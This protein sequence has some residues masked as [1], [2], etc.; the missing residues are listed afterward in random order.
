M[1]RSRQF[2]VRQ[3]AIAASVMLISGAQPACAQSSDFDAWLEEVRSEAAQRGLTA[4]AVIDTLA[5]IQL[6][7]RV[8]ELDQRQPELV[9]TFW[10][11]VDARVTPGR[12]AI[13]EGL[14]STYETLLDEVY[15]RYGVQPRIIVALWGMESDY[16]RAQGDFDV[17]SSL[18]T[19]AFD[20]RR[21]ALFRSQLFALLALINQGDVP[22]DVR[23]SW[24]G[25][26]GQPQFM[27]TTFSRYAVDFDGDGRRDLQGDVADVFASA[28]NYLALSG[29]ERS[30]GWGQEVLLPSAFDFAETGLDERKPLEEWQRLGVRQIDGRDLPLRAL[31]G[32]ILLPAGAKGPAFLVYDNFRA[33]LAWNNSALF[34]LAVGILSDELAG[35]GPLQTPRPAEEETLS[36]YDV[37][38]LQ[39]RLVGLGFAA[40]EADGVVGEQTRRAIRLFQKSADLPAD[41]YPD[42]ELL[43]Q[44]RVRSDP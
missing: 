2:S 37:V 43:R 30:A 24:A 7:D 32:S 22:G 6:V 16:G 42:P 23:G 8:I 44:L 38:E 34:A 18:A 15:Q 4:P 14:L 9:Q 5:R 20:S 10:R 1:T 12:V 31:T 25:A 17:A 11:Y 35:G 26:I 36:R 21:S 27:P 3:L 28:A 39:S 29:W 41:G 33:L 19:L 13:G 40:G